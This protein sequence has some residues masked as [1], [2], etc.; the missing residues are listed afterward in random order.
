M[1]EDSIKPFLS[2]ANK[3]AVGFIPA[4]ELAILTLE[5]DSITS[6]H[7]SPWTLPIFILITDWPLTDNH[8]NC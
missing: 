2:S 7:C 5:L 6:R 8:H 3:E 4:Q 1:Y